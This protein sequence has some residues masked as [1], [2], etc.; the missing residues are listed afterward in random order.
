MTVLKRTFLAFQPH[1][2][3][4][5]VGPMAFPEQRAG[6]CHRHINVLSSLWDR[7]NPGGDGL[8][9][10]E[11]VQ[12][13]LHIFAWP[14]PFCQGRGESSPTATQHPWGCQSLPQWH[15]QSCT[16]TDWTLGTQLSPLRARAVQSPLGPTQPNPCPDSIHMLT[17][18]CS[19]HVHVATYSNRFILQLLSSMIHLLNKEIGTIWNLC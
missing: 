12:N 13:Y 10:S 19:F 4:A 9:L 7:W 16:K 2:P 14:A 18:F 1:A 6:R 11:P 15:S 8:S 17:W 5:C 3:E